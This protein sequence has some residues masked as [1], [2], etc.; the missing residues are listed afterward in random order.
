MFMVI[1][2]LGSKGEAGGPP[3]AV[4]GALLYD[5]WLLDIPKLLDLCS[6]YAHSNPTP[7]RQLLTNVFELQPKYL[8]D[9]NGAP[10]QHVQCVGCCEGAV[11]EEER[12]IPPRPS[13]G[14]CIVRTHRRGA[15]C[16]RLVLR[17][18]GVRSAMRDSHAPGCVI[19]TIDNLNQMQRSTMQVRPAASI[20]RPQRSIG[21]CRWDVTLLSETTSC[22]RAFSPHGGW[23]GSR[24]A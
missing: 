14:C 15:I 4:H 21:W 16:R 19:T 23:R 12:V 6:L 11:A 7:L 9:L 5:N 13:L 20:R 2:R 17:R 10:A 3:P 1:L 8:D 22:R 18:H 24:A